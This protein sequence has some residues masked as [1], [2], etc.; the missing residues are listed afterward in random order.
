MLPF[1]QR[2]ATGRAAPRPEDWFEAWS[3][4]SVFP[5]LVHSA[6]SLAFP[7]T[8]GERKLAELR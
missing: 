7:L 6:I 2:M 8:Y 4:I 1:G 3:K 5:R